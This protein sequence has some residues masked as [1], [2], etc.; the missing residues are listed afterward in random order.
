M[1]GRPSLR[2]GKGPSLEPVIYVIKTRTFHLLPSPALLGVSR[3]PHSDSSMLSRISNSP[4]LSRYHTPPT[5]SFAIISP[6]THSRTFVEV[7]TIDRFVCALRP[8]ILFHKRGVLYF[9]VCSLSLD[10]AFLV[11]CL[12]GDIAGF[13][14]T[15]SEGN[16]RQM[17]WST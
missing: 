9:C 14:S 7:H 4:R 12:Q 6:A 2:S 8:L 3:R 15:H 5:M 1:T 17:T 16:G 13:F 11:L 10:W